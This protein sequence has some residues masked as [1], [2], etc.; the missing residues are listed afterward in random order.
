[1][2]LIDASGTLAGVVAPMKSG[3]PASDSALDG[4]PK[5]EGV[6]LQGALRSGGMC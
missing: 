3:V 5:A 6:D 1:V 4:S 2:L